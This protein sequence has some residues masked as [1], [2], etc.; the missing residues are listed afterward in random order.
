MLK[1]NLQAE[2]SRRISAMTNNFLEGGAKAY[3]KALQAQ[4]R[5]EL[6]KLHAQLK[7]AKMESE[8]LQIEQQIARL[9]ETYR[10][11]S[12]ATRRGIF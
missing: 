12:Q 3:G 6:D 4:H 1:H 8:R 7:S 11:K 10:E 5:E 9:N 2:L